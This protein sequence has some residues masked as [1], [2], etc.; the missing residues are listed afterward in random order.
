METRLPPDFSELLSS[1]NASGV[2][3]LL[4]GGYAV[5]YYGYP[6]AT[7]DIDV[8]VRQSPDNAERV[9]TA[10][11]AFGFDV[12]GLVPTALLGD[13]KIIRMGVPPN[14]AKVFT[15]VSG[16]SFDECWAQRE[17]VD[18]GGVEVPV[19]GLRDLRRNKRASGRPADLDELPAPPSAEG[20]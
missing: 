4:V 19:I 2:E 1:L 11:R 18:W 16:V 20:E 6:R 12:P 14:R 8:W 9:V 15:S 17:V 5:I 10:L 7:G 3:Y 13:D